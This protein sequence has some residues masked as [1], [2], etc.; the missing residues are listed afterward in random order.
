[1]VRNWDQ[2]RLT[3]HSRYWITLICRTSRWESPLPSKSPSRGSSY[4]NNN[5][6]WWYGLFVNITTPTMYLSNQSKQRLASFHPLYQN[7]ILITQRSFL[8][9]L[10]KISFVLITCLAFTD[11]DSDS[12]VDEV[13]HIRNRTTT[14][15]RPY[16]NSFRLVSTCHCSRSN[17]V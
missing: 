12:V 3:E 6:W 13:V 5:G 16:L 10:P 7:G 17:M 14:S 1:M 15:K 11:L 4:S 9:W 8:W 2:K